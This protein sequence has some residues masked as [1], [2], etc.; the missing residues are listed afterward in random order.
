[1]ASTEIRRIRKVDCTQFLETGNPKFDYDHN[2]NKLN[3]GFYY[4]RDK[5]GRYESYVLEDKGKIFGVLCIQKQVD[6]LYLSRLGIQKN[7][8]RQHHGAQLLKFTILRAIELKLN[9]VHL[10]TVAENIPFY[11]AL[12]FKVV[13]KYRDSYWGE[14]ATMELTF[15][16]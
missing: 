9:K 16:T 1:V 5:S 12:G 11:E 2:G 10:K 6:S 13:R 14:S 3:L 4:R 8:Q 15:R 7:H